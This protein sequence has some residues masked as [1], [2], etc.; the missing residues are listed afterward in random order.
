[1][2]T[3]FLKGILLLLLFIGNLSLLTAQ[4][5][6]PNYSFETLA[7]CPES[8]GGSGPTAAPPW[9]APTQGT[10]DIF[11]V[12][13]TSGTVDVPTNF[14]GNQEALTGV[15]YAGGYT[16][17]P[18]FEYREYMSAPLDQPLIAGE[19]YAVSFYVSP[20]EFGCSVM[21]IG[22]YFSVTQPTGGVTHIDVDPQIES[23]L[24]FI[25]DYAN[26]TLIS[27]C[28]QAAGGE[29]Y[30]T[31]G[32]FYSDA[33]TDDNPLCS[34]QQ[35]LSYYYYE[36]VVV[37]E[38]AMPGLLDLELNGP[39]TACFSY[40][41]DPGIPDVNYTWEDGSHNPTLV[42]TESGV[43]S[44]TI[45]DGCNYGVDSIEITI[46]GNHEAPDIGPPQLTLCLGDEY[47]IMLDPELTEYE[48][49]DGSNGPDYTI[50]TAGTYAVTLDDGCA[51]YTDEI[52]V[53]YMAPPSPFDLG[54]DDILCFGD[55]VDFSFDPS[56]GDF[57]WQ[58]NTTLPTYTVSIGGTYSLTISNMCGIESDEIEFTDLEVP[59]IEIGPD[60]Q[61]LCDGEILEIEIDPGLGDILWQDGSS[62]PNYEI[63]NAGL[64][65]VFVTN[66]C[67]TGIDNI[68]V[69]V[70]QS[71]DIDLGSD[72]ILC[73][74]ETLLL[75]TNET[76]PYLWQDNST[77]DYF[78][79]S[80]PGTY[81]L[82][83]SNFCG[84]GSD[85]VNVGYTSL[86][87]PPDFG[88]DVSLCPGEQIILYANNPGAEYL[89]QDFSTAD[90]LIVNSSGTYVVQVFNSCSLEADTIVV[91]VYDSPPLVDLPSQLNLCQGLSVTLDVAI[92]GVNYLWNDNSQ[93]QQLL[94]NA[95]GT[96]SVTVSNSCGME[97]DTTI[98]ID[99]GPA[100]SAAL[101]N[102]I[103]IC[104]GDQVVLSPV[105]SNVDT[106]LW[107]DG[108]ASATYTV[109]DV[110]LVT[111]EVSNACGSAFD[112][113]QVGLFTASP[114]LDLGTDT[115]L[116][117]G[118][119]FTLSINTPGVT[120]L[121]PD[122]STGVSYNVTGIGQVFAEISN[123]C[124]TSF[125]TIQ[126]NALPDV[127][128]L[129]LGVDQTLCPGEIIT[130]TPGIANVEYL[131]QD[132][133]TGNSYL[134]TLEETI[135]LIISN[136]CSSTS[137]TLEVIESTQGPQVDLGNDILVCA[138]EIVTIQSGI[139]GVNYLWQDGASTPDYT[140][141]QSGV[142]VLIVNNSCGAD[143]DTITV[144]I[145]GVPPTPVL[146]PDTTLCEGIT[147]LLISS[148]DAETSIEWQDGSSTPTFMVSSAGTYTLSES[149]RCGDAADTMTINYL[150]G[151][152]P[153]SLGSDTTLCPG[154]SITLAA[155]STS[156]EISWQDGS[157]QPTIVA[158][159]AL[160]YSLQLSND[161]GV[162]YDNIV[163]V[164]DT[165]I[166]QLNLDPSISWCE[167]DI[168]NLDASQPFVAGYLWND[169]SSTPTLQVTTPGLYS[170]EV[171]TPCNTVSQEVVVYPGTDCIIPEVNNEIYIPNVF[172][173]N[174]DGINDIF[175]MSFGADLEVT[176]MEGTIFD[177]WGNLMYGSKENPFNW[178][179]FFDD[180]LVMPGVCV[181]VIRIEYLLGGIAR[182]Q[183]LY[184]DVTVV[185]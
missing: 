149:N 145:S 47:E 174:G 22:A 167:G 41:I 182:Q 13:C 139:S 141:N 86:V 135:I 119:S 166:P 1:M 2:A 129:N 185:R 73:D 104:P 112:T 20:A 144:D 52:T 95:P 40:E 4:N 70:I 134:S 74:G 164:Y 23:D 25:S 27:G 65:T 148:A 154:E 56:L 84:T 118:E 8:F 16:K 38:G 45:S 67:G 121:W 109:D 146:G 136:D 83:I 6:V 3:F 102:D 140:T 33:E 12:C 133:S 130:L 120:I 137:D 159:Q 178:D 28:F 177:R 176:A 132:G 64:Y 32:N 105:F 181:Y 99:G 51:V 155:P 5:L 152:N 55:E 163:I 150:D 36:D 46:N 75:S 69:T 35:T 94:V 138:S 106:W 15:G 76:G 30:I 131:W 24:G 77:E 80:G 125:D 175:S 87:S 58:D 180:E 169:G 9:I 100:P 128:L 31:L 49:Q 157:T 42:V 21:T 57:L 39:E 59:E 171:T 126:V 113:L 50:T 63:V 108:S 44:L 103:Q 122:G 160:I 153:F 78:L 66:G 183:T 34:G 19:W 170:I 91:T 72:T 90:S 123:N 92:S 184:G 142:F 110:G 60:E 14:F 93:N 168:I 115:S 98:I 18:Q 127:P 29:Q 143:T 54:N 53:F 161:C 114:P 162:V 101:G 43:Y 179:G 11:N 88:S 17:L 96:Y 61:T 147:L 111:V 82:T 165:R 107:Q 81:S 158:D 172:S 85:A 89:W 79:V 97:T 7:F 156:F 151:P 116:C 48:W 117:S 10:P 37:T 173:P 71:P 124:G 62:E 68:E 26:W